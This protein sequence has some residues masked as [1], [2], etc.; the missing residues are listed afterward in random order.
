VGKMQNVARYSSWVNT[1]TTVP[2]QTHKEV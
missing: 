2:A 1:I